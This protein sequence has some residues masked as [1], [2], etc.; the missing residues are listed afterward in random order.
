MVMNINGVIGTF[1]NQSFPVNGT[2]VFGRNPNGCNILFPD[3]VRG[4]SRVHCS[5]EK[6]GNQFVITDLGSSYGTFL[7]GNKL[8]PNV[9]V[10][11]KNGD[12]FY[13]GD[14]S[15][16]FKVQDA[17]EER[18]NS[19]RILP[20]SG[21]Q[22][23]NSQFSRKNMYLI[24]GFSVAAVLVIVIGIGVFSSV[25]QSK[26]QA[27]Q[28]QMQAQQAQLQAQQEAWQAQQEA[29]KAQQEAWQAQQQLNDELNK[30]PLE[31]TFDAI[32]DWVDFFN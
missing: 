16:L 21:A 17:S 13:L 20:G 31:K 23:D 27:L 11:L 9:P 2:V 8:Q 28:A 22:A 10:P 25:S 7:N 32:M 29:Q 19:P 12:S 18:K 30:G 6:K 15:N 26:Q 3:N 1:E 4:I 5:V 24:I 14:K